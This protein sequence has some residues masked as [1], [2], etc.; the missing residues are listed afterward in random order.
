[1]QAL[2]PPKARMRSK[3]CDSFGLAVIPQKL[4]AGK[5][6]YVCGTL[7][8]VSWWK[9]SLRENLNEIEDSDPNEELSREN[10]LQAYTS[11]LAVPPAKSKRSNSA[12]SDSSYLNT[13]EDKR[14]TSMRITRSASTSMEQLN[15]N[16]SAKQDKATSTHDLEWRR[17][18]SRKTNKEHEVI[19][20]DVPKVEDFRWRKNSKDSTSSIDNESNLTDS[21]KV[22]LLHRQLVDLQTQSLTERRKY[23]DVRRYWGD[24]TSLHSSLE[25]NPTL[26]RTLSS[27]S[28]LDTNEETPSSN[29]WRRVSDGA[30]ARSPPDI[31]HG[32]RHSFHEDELETVPEITVSVDGYHGDDVD[33][34]GSCELDSPPS[35]Q[36]DNHS[37]SHSPM[38]SYSNDEEDVSQTSPRSSPPLLTI[39]LPAESL[40]EI[41]K[42]SS[43]T[44]PSIHRGFRRPPLGHTV[45]LPAASFEHYV[46]VFQGV[47]G[48]RSDAEETIEEED[49]EDLDEDEIPAAALHRRD[50]RTSVD[51]DEIYVK[52]N[53]D[54]RQKKT[55]VS[56]RFD[57][58]VPREH[59]EHL[60]AD[61][62]AYLEYRKQCPQE[63]NHTDSSASKPNEEDEISMAESAAIARAR[64]L[65]RRRGSAVVTLPGERSYQMD[66]HVFNK[67]ADRF[68]K[69]LLHE[70][71]M[72]HD[73]RD[74]S[75]STTSLNSIGDPEK[76]SRW[77]I[78]KRNKKIIYGK[79]ARRQTEDF[80]EA[81]SQLRENP[82]GAIEHELTEY[83]DSHW[84][85]LIPS[86][87]GTPRRPLSE[88][89]SSL[90]SQETKRREALWE[91]FHSEV[92]YLIDHLLVLNEVFLEP[93]KLLQHMG[94]LC[95]VN[96]SK[97]FSNVKGLC[98]VSAKFAADLLLVFKG[99]QSKQFGNTAAVVTA[100]T[101]FGSKLQPQYQEYC[102][103]YSKVLGYL[104]HC[105]KSDDFQEYVK[106][107]EAD[108][109][110]NRL[111]LT[112]LLVAPLQ[113]LTKYPL[114]L[115]NIR[116]RTSEGEDEHSSLSSV[117]KSVE[118]S[119]KELE[120]K[121][122]S[123]ANF[124]R[125]QELQNCLV[126]PSIIELD[127]K[128]YV[129]E[130][131][132]GILAKQPCESL[133]TSPKRQLLYEGPLVLLEN[134]K[135]DIYAFLFDDMLLLT[136]YR[137]YQQKINKKLSLAGMTSDSPPPT[138]PVVRKVTT[139]GQYTVYKQPIPLD[140]FIIIDA[141]AT[142]AGNTMKNTFIIIHYS[143]FKQTIGL[144]TLQAP[145]Q[146]LKE[147][148][149]STLKSAQGSWSEA[150]AS[151]IAAEAQKPPPISNPEEETETSERI[152]DESVSTNRMLSYHKPIEYHC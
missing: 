63:S 69:S 112:D 149:T 36:D 95:V 90:S 125:L 12:D 1:M 142:H 103:N 72:L 140:R 47:N 53:R 11:R 141:E 23:S 106:W 107:C 67:Q 117:I 127:P 94:Y 54:K 115:K 8:K 17:E 139:T 77:S 10:E 152:S 48:S 145:S 64:S 39:E 3:S 46:S 34:Q 92:V 151:E 73:K 133:L 129:P 109:R 13:D 121:V 98:E 55:S 38:L 61:I 43:T 124:E 144:Y 25:V 76:R 29:P 62:A 9:R 108:P 74:L 20:S 138:P 70:K 110:C 40:N 45:S 132:R 24:S 128:T 41:E 97:I 93:L 147:T 21:T 31:P 116:E 146:N 80:K 81:L 42:P 59:A 52:K 50:R 130:F 51:D 88:G 7:D 100:F 16:V 28:V 122:K 49:E 105:K 57:G 79:D 111:Q 123:L 83:K 137:K 18:G 91:L 89:F 66:L 99:D 134:T 143:R 26:H 58:D 120:G 113:H 22:R 71:S 68:D 101:E 87:R 30:V 6:V 96:S 118:R 85:Q 84:T 126:W 60:A 82:K 56:L 131:L 135:Q 75:G 5:V 37:T 114:L 78:L 136:R 44:H 27:P 150:V 2:M 19:S 102:L 86:P 35:T 104:D 32:I 33:S 65:S 14:S 148:W 4:R 15:R 119:I